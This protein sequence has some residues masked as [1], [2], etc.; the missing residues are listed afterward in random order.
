MFYVYVLLSIKDKRFYTGSTVDLRKR[1]SQHNNQE[2]LSTKGRGPFALI[3]YEACLNEKDARIR[4]KYL[5]TGM[6]K[7]YIKNRLKR[8]L[9]LTG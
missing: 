6:G 1:F 9:A 2:V 5:K 4:E 3:Y 7:R 8:F